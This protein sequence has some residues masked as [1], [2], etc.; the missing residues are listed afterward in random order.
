MREQRLEVWVIACSARVT[1]LLELCHEGMPAMLPG[2]QSWRQRCRVADGGLLQTA[3][4]YGRE[5]E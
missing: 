1:R 5:P 3:A 4:Q 2:C